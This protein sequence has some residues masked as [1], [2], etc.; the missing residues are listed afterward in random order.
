MNKRASI[1]VGT[2]IALVSATAVIAQTGLFETEP[3]APA[4]AVDVAK[5][6]G[7]RAVLLSNKPMAI[8]GNRLTV[9]SSGRVLDPQSCVVAEGM[10]RHLSTLP[11]TGAAYVIDQAG[12][13]VLNRVGPEGT[14][15]IASGIEIT[16]P[17]WSP[18]GQLAWAENLEVLK[19]MSADGAN[20]SGVVLP[21][22]AVAAFSPLFVDEQHVM[23]VVQEQVEGAPPED[24]SLNNLWVFD[25]SSGRWSKKTSF[26]ASGDNWV[27]IRTPVTAA[28][29]SIYFVRI[30]ANASETKE[31][32][33]EL[34][35]Y[36][37]G[38]A[39]KVRSLASE[40][41]LAGI[42]DEHRLWNAPSRACGDWGLFIENADGLDPV[43]CGAVMTDPVAVPDPDQLVDAE[44]AGGGVTVPETEDLT[45]L[46][47][48]VGDFESS[49]AAAA[50]A[51]GLDRAA[52][53]IGHDGAPSALRPGAWGLLVQIAAGVPVDQDL[54][55][56]RA[57]LRGCDC[58]AWLAPSV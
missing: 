25:L 5:D 43:G 7:D 41:Y 10:L 55:A 48:V 56:V 14:V 1:L 12:Q 26:H 9:A 21:K 54:E 4:C 19:V 50:V 32:R 58:G 52:R 46:V 15:A 28:D 27:G 8:S 53:V 22:G 2:A 36:S 24:E 17:A 49:A 38:S 37:S 3:A 18:A 29:G 44:H 33:F 51:S 57:Q 16:H 35:R 20:V 6:Q 34:W 31:P 11:G 39:S 30:S 42:V 40:M 13:D 23:A 47:I 45:D